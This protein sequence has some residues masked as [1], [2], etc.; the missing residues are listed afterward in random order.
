MESPLAML[1]YS[2]GTAAFKYLPN[3]GIDT[4]KN[5]IKLSIRMVLVVTLLL[6]CLKLLL[7]S[8]QKMI[9]L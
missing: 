5:N 8:I 9:P 4:R 1:C 6:F 2:T 3:V 7:E